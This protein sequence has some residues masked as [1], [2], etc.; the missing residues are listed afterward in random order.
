MLK[1]LNASKRSCTYHPSFGRGTLLNKEKSMLYTAGPR[2][3]FLPR[4]PNEPDGAANAQGLNHVCTVWTASAASPPCEM[5]FA[6]LGFGFDG[7][8]PAWKGSAI[9]LGRA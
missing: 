1:M 7:T 5:V 6:H 3:G 8:G 9:I 4:F 2:N